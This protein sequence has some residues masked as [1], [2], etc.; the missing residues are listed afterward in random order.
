MKLDVAIVMLLG[1]VMIVAGTDLLLG[2]IRKRKYRQ[3]PRGA[4]DVMSG[5]GCIL[6]VKALVSG[7]DHLLL[8][9]QIMLF[10]G[11]VIMLVLLALYSDKS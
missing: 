9:G 7:G 10:V 5:A 8:L 11:L 3:I 2:G 6:I 1:I 4:G